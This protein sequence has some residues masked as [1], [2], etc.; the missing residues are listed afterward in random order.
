MK[1][2]KISE[3]IKD[4]LEEMVNI[5][6]GNAAGA[7]E[8]ILKY[9]FD[10]V[11]PLVHILPPHKAFSA[12]G[13]PSKPVVGVKMNMIG[14]VKGELFFMIPRNQLDYV[15]ELAQS[16]IG[17]EQKKGS[18][19]DLSI[20]VEIGNILAGVYLT[21]IHDFCHLN[22]YHTVPLLAVDM[23]QSLMDET[24][25]RLGVTARIL[26]IIVNKFSSTL[27]NEKAIDTFLIMI[28]S[29]GSDQVLMD[30]IREA[31]RSLGR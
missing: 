8:E 21:A 4:Y 15:L 25:A 23:V 14:D 19:P 16:S 31:K 10:M 22:I 20:I 11:L 27:Q 1:E 30:S 12:I 3:E 2:E 9:R 18:D 28:P 6:A 13:E 29:K 26:I 17:L 24:I 7:L 5:G